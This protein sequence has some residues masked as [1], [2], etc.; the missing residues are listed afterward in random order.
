MH[1]YNFTYNINSQTFLSTKF[2][3][4]VYLCFVLVPCT[5][6]SSGLHESRVLKNSGELALFKRRGTLVLGSFKFL[7]RSVKLVLAY[8]SKCI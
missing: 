8:Y 6:L 3:A 4:S 1:P 5:A 7:I 2:L